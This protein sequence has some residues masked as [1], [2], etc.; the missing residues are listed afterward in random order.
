MLFKDAAN[1]AANVELTSPNTITL[2]IFSLL[3]KIDKLFKTQ[4]NPSIE[5]FFGYSI[6]L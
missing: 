3:N 2:S 5:E 6:L 4:A 1:A